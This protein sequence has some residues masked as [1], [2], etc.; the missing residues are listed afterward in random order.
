[1]TGQ[2]T[3]WRAQARAE[4]LPVDLP[5]TAVRFGSRAGVRRVLAADVTARLAA[6]ARAA[7][8]GLSD[9]LLAATAVAVAAWQGGNELTVA[10]AAPGRNGPPGHDVDVTRTVGWFQY[11]YP[12]RLRLGR[13]STL[14]RLAGELRAQIGAVPMHGLGHGLLTHAH[15]DPAVREEMA[16]SAGPQVSFN[17]LG[18]IGSWDRQPAARV[19]RPSAHPSGTAQDPAG[20]WPYLLDIAGEL[21]EGRLRFVAHH[22][23]G[24]HRT[25][26]VDGLM[27]EIVRLLDGGAR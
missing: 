3:F 7:G 21:R 2:R 6:E 15:P 22:G 23:T 17:Y 26:T 1:M 18:E 11:F 9:L 13:P 14:P 10:L 16:R 27:D 12:L 5:G 19:L 8:T 24:L 25:A 4:E 20:R